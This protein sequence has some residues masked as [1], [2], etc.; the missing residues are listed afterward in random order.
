MSAVLVEDSIFGPVEVTVDCEVG[1]MSVSG[2]GLSP[3]SIRRS[4]G[5]ES[6]GRSPIGTRTPGRLEFILN[7]DVLAIEPGIGYLSRKS[8]RVDVKYEGHV[9]RFVPTANLRSKLLRDGQR[10]GELHR[11]PVHARWEADANV[12]PTEA[13]MAYVLAAA[14]GVGAPGLVKASIGA[15]VVSPPF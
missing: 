12:L 10:I 6:D 4:R 5:T 7:G 8:R 9:Y 2:P 1:C 11:A 15:G 13:A 3:A 14:F